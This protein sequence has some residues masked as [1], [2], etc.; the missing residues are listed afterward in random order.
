[1][2][3]SKYWTQS[4]EVFLQLSAYFFS[5]LFR[6]PVRCMLQWQYINVD[7]IMISSRQRQH[8]FVVHILTYWLARTSYLFVGWQVHAEL[9]FSKKNN[10]C[11]LA[12]DFG[13][14]HLLWVY[15]GRRGVHC[16][17]C[18]TRARRYV[19]PWL[20]FSMHAFWSQ[21]LFP[22]VPRSTLQSILCCLSHV[23]I[24]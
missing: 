19:I 9:S 3:P 20:N 10:N 23:Q 7:R 6:F 1:M 8:C 2:L 22:E 18:D 4:F 24:E 14:E 16:W 5:L 21:I 12:E 11:I 13:F 15:S 17:V